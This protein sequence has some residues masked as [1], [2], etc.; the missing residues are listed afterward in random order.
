M[1]LD[2]GGAQIGLVPRAFADA[3][4][5]VHLFRA[6]ADNAARPVI[7]EAAAEKPLALAMTAEASV[8]PA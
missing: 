7:F 2:L 6:E 4:Q 8:S 5:R 1:K 3:D